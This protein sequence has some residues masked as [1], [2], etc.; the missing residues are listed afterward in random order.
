MSIA[1]WDQLAKRRRSLEARARSV[2]KMSAEDA[3]D[4]AQDAI[5]RVGAAKAESEDEVA[6][7]YL[8]D[9]LDS[10]AKDR[11]RSA[12]LRAMES[13]DGARRERSNIL[14]DPQLAYIVESDPA[15]KALKDMPSDCRTAFTLICVQGKTYD[16]CAAA[17][18]LPRERVAGLLRRARQRMQSALS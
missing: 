5:L 7:R 8:S 9:A 13:L 12:S 2:W 6:N 16:E 15:V 17:M 18:R 11:I 14:R 3:Q 10:V 1:L 4:A